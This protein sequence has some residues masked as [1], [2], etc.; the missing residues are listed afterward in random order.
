MNANNAESPTS[1][2]RMNSETSSIQPSS[3]QTTPSSSPEVSLSNSESTP[4]SGK[5][6]ALVPD[7]DFDTAPLRGLV[8]N[9]MD[10]LNLE[11]LRAKVVRIR[12]L[13]TP[14]VFKAEVEAEGRTSKDK[15]SVARMAKQAEAFGDLL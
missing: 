11:E 15:A 6:F 10:T 1:P 5:S 13:R 4:P 2:E 3:S 8:D 7:T 12:Q 9:P 14:Q